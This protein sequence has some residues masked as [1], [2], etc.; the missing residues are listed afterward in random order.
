MS[1]TAHWIGQLKESVNIKTNQQ[2]LYTEK[3][4]YKNDVKAWNIMRIT[5][6]WQRDL[7]WENTV[8][9]MVPGSMSDAGLL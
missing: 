5:K 4:K 8:G 3:N 9:K 6:M 2:Q 1:I 7:K